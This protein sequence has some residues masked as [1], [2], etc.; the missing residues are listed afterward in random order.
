MKRMI[1]ALL[2][3]GMPLTTSRSGDRAPHRVPQPTDAASA[4]L[5]I[6]TSGVASDIETKY[7]GFAHETKITLNRMRISCGGKKG[8]F[9]G[10]VADTCISFSA[11][12]HCPGLQLDYVSY[13]KLQLIFDTK[14]WDR[15]HSPE[16][17]DLIVV[18]DDEQLKLGRMSLVKQDVGTDRLVDV[19][20]EVLEVSFP[21]QT[22]RKLAAAQNIEVKV[23]KTT[24]SLTPKNIAAL[25]E[26]NNRVKPRS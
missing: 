16:E 11:S 13:A 3:L 21:Y 2:C 9:Q 8:G 24:F 10:A 18:A 20:R 6:V 1:I 5:P 4:S 15:R 17:R 23:G 12:L 14:D 7:D 26:M 19:M 22:F 25:R